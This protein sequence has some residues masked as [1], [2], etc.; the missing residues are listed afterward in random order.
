MNPPS[1]EI[2]FLILSGVILAAGVLYWFWSH[3]QLTQKKVQLLENA[4]FELRGML[5]PTEITQHLEPALEPTSQGNQPQYRDLD[6]D[7]WTDRNDRNDRNDQPNDQVRVA[8]VEATTQET[9]QI[10]TQVTREE[11]V[12]MTTELIQGFANLYTEDVREI[13]EPEAEPKSEEAQTLEGMTLKQL[14]RMATERGITGTS[15]MKKKALVDAI[16]N[17]VNGPPV[18]TEL[19]LEAF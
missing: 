1:M 7:D 2:M 4:V 8:I 13:A 16:R 3:I 12:K 6:D 15:E 19:T 18:E 5:A 14:R 9:P 11:P 10:Q 17:T